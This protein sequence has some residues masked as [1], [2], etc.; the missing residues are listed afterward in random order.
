MVKNRIEVLSDYSPSQSVPMEVTAS[1]VLWEDEN[2]NEPLLKVVD[3]VFSN[4]T[5]YPEIEWSKFGCSPPEMYSP[6]GAWRDRT[7]SVFIFLLSYSTRRSQGSS[8]TLL[9]YTKGDPKSVDAVQKKVAGIKS[10]IAKNETRDST[11]QNA[12]D[13]LI[14][15]DRTNS[16]HKLIKLAGLF[17]IIINVF[18][19]YLQRL[20][21]PTFPT[22]KIAVAYQIILILIHFL[23]LTLLIVLILLFI[24]YVIRYG[25]LVLRKF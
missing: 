6:Q 20:P 7:G 2:A 5:F 12:R 25:L 8:P 10:D 21:A 18:S 15:E 24:G 23:A 16:A 11:I 14:I 3:S 1:W 22:Q 19:V 13:C 9:L 4:Y 17:T